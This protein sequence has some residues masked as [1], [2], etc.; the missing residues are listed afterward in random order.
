MVILILT[1][2]PLFLLWNGYGAMNKIYE[3][4]KWTFIEKLSNYQIL[5][6]FSAKPSK[7]Q[8]S[9]FLKLSKSISGD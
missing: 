3:C 6:D 8:V 5:I 4:K 2:I 9:L 1:I 7:S